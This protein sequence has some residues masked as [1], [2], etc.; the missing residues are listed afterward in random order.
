M[1]SRVLPAHCMLLTITRMV[2]V[3][4]APTPVAV[5]LLS[6]RSSPNCS[7][8]ALRLS[9]WFPDTSGCSLFTLSPLSRLDLLLGW[10]WWHKL[11][12]QRLS[13]RARESGDQGLPQVERKE[14]R[15]RRKKGGKK[16]IKGNKLTSQRCCLRVSVAM[17]RHHDQG[18]P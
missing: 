7:S 14:G 5:F 18:N 3:C 11:I 9:G 12:I 6:L 10:R 17:N 1:T 13:S 4:P 16:K 8:L 2:T 15:E